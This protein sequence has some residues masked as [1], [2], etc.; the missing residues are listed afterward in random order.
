ML[1]QE[2]LL[3]ETAFDDKDVEGITSVPQGLA[4]SLELEVDTCVVENI[5]MYAYAL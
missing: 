5:L 4:S 1:Q 2:L 3:E